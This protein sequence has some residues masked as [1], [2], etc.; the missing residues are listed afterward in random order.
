MGNQFGSYYYKTFFYYLPF[1]IGQSS[2]DPTFLIKPEP[3]SLA[4]N[5]YR[6][7]AIQDFA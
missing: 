3:L 5:N 6:S 1:S 7:I 4:L 2:D